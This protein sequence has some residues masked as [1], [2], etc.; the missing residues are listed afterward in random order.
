M[1]LLK[2]STSNLHSDMLE[3]GKIEPFLRVM[4]LVGLIILPVLSILKFINQ[5]KLFFNDYI[6]F[7]LTLALLFFLI[8][9]K[10]NVRLVSLL[11]IFS[12]WAG[13]TAIAYI[14]EGVHNVTII[15]YILIIFIS[16]LLSSY[17]IAF[18]VTALSITS[19]WI[20]AYLEQ[21]GR[22]A[23]NRATPLIFSRD[24]TI[25][26]IMVIT[27]IILYEKSFQ[28]SYNRI[29]EELNERKA[30]EAKL[31]KNELALKLQNDQYIALNE[32][33]T[34]SNNL[35]MSMNFDLKAAKEK[36]EQNDRLKTAFLQNISHEIRTPLNGIMGFTDLLKGSET[37][38]EK[39]Y[40]NI[41]KQS[42]TKL[43]TLLDDLIDISKIEAGVIS[44]NISPFELKSVFHEL[45]YF[46]SAKVKEKGLELSFETNEINIVETDRLKI[47]Q[48]VNNLISNAY[49][50]TNTGFIRVIA[51]SEG[52]LLSITVQDS[53]IGIK[54]DDIDIIF[55]RFTQADMGLN[56]SYGGTGL[57]LSIT[58]SLVEYLGGKITVISEL[59]KGSE[60]KISIPAT[61]LPNQAESIQK[62][63]NSPKLFSRKIKILVAE[64][65]DFNFFYLR[66]ILKNRNCEIIRAVD[67]QE[68][69]DITNE[70]KNFDLILMD[71]KMPN[72]NGYEA[73][74]RIKSDFPNLPIFAITAYAF[75]QENL[76]KYHFHFDD[77]I[78]KPVIRQVLLD[79]IHNFLVV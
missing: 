74:E 15:A 45:E 35:I 2:F 38:D 39:E 40:I 21:I 79:K 55:D 33:L 23:S 43:S 18:L 6:L 42:C 58:K 63:P 72:L 53:G 11:F 34:E 20:L 37:Q 56:R 17:R 57:G 48:M 52:D 61:F 46:Y 67:G 22:I 44:I 69:V 60:F 3:N 41:I 29:N 49:K 66:E 75:K 64:D 73:M 8:I 77:Y 26:T 70:H 7:G 5:H 76:G 27:L 78:S 10:K 50:F 71:I 25:I 19:V 51:R 24:Y 28:Y 31:L 12:S 13:M 65:E 36:A 1:R 59:G 9:L 32:E 54:A 30:A 47:F 14:A 68:A 4:L 62:V 16:S